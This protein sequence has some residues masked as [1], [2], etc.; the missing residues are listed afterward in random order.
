MVLGANK[1][2]AKNVGPEAHQVGAPMSPD[3]GGLAGE[4]YG[5]VVAS[6]SFDD[7]VYY[8]RVAMAKEERKKMLKR[9]GRVPAAAGGVAAGIGLTNVIF[10][11]TIDTYEGAYDNA[12]T[13]YES[14]SSGL[15]IAKQVGNEVAGDSWE[16]MMKVP[17]PVYQDYDSSVID[18]AN[19]ESVDLDKF[20]QIEINGDSYMVSAEM[21][22]DLDTDKLFYSKSP[23]VISEDSGMR[24]DYLGDELIS[25]Y[26][27]APD[28]DD[29]RMVGLCKD[30][31]KGFYATRVDGQGYSVYKSITNEDGTRE[32][33]LEVD[34]PTDAVKIDIGEEDGGAIYKAFEKF[35]ELVGMDDPQGWADG[36]ATTLADNPLLFWGP[37]GAIGGLL[38]W[39]LVQPIKRMRNMYYTLFPTKS[40]RPLVDFERKNIEKRLQADLEP[41][42]RREL[43][44]ARKY[45]EQRGRFLSETASQIVA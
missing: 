8:D 38:L 20:G 5:A 27:K 9:A 30:G 43:E 36:T 34:I 10:P 26:A 12:K 6:R 13:E 42:I 19:L 3:Y 15:E 11:E 21:D 37:A 2:S 17:E 23:A 18:E 32:G 41:G 16:D 39:N 22:L 1:Y 35:A 33:F 29:Y 14:G 4:M 45:A 44:L 25:V 7:K 24:E 31:G 40:T 28:S